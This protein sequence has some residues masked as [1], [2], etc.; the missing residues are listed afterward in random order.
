MPNWLV[1]VIL[2]NVRLRF[3]WKMRIEFDL[4]DLILRSRFEITVR[5]IKTADTC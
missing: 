3:S 5:L 4:D 1:S 2:Q